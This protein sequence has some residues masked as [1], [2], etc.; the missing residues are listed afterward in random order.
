VK[1]AALEPS[2]DDVKRTFETCKEFIEM[3]K[4]REEVK[5]EAAP[6]PA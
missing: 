4:V 5:A 1:F 3:T 6:S 2:A